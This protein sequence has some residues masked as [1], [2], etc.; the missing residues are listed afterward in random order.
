MTIELLRG[1]FFIL[2]DENSRL[3]ELATV[4]MTHE[5]WRVTSWRAELERVVAV[6]EVPGNALAG[7]ADKVTEPPDSR[8]ELER[9][10][11]AG[12]PDK[13][14]ALPDNLDLARVPMSHENWRVTSRRGEL[15][16]TPELG[17]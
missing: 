10:E 2:Y 12:T 3:S 5:G 13:V 1:T 7:T 4:R 6:I 16:P 17:R 8:G 11:T 15:G 9:R 14:T